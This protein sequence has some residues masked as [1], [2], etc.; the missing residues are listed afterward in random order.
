MLLMGFQYLSRLMAKIGGYKLDKKGQLKKAIRGLGHKKGL[1]KNNY[2]RLSNYEILVYML[3][4][5]LGVRWI[6][7][8]AIKK[9]RQGLPKMYQEE[10][11]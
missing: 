7:E 5:R 1:T 2:Y 3:E 4:Q 9:L 11:I 10:K 8:G 6:T